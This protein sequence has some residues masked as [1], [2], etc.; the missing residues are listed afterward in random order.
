MDKTRY[1]I[2]GIFIIIA[3]SAVYISQMNCEVKEKIETDLNPRYE[4]VA[5]NYTD[6]GNQTPIK[7]R[8]K[9]ITGEEP[10]EI[11]SGAN[12]SLNVVFDSNTTEKK[13]E[14]IIF[15]YNIPKPLLIK[16]SFS[17]PEYYISGSMSDFESIKNHLDEDKYSNIQLAGKIKITGENFTAAV[18]GVYDDILPELRLSGIQLKETMVMQLIYGHETPQ[19]ES[20]NIM[21]QLDSDEKIIN[22]NV[23][24]LFGEERT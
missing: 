7:I 2:I 1:Y 13:A 3:L 15:K 22:T 14:E 9:L 6:R 5:E 23:G 17:Y 10:I 11:N 12:W 4:K 20:R 8:G 16:R 21:Q 19:T 24:Y 18:W